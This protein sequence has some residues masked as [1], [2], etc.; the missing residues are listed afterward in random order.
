MKIP[1]IG[2]VLADKY[3]V[4]AIVGH[5][6]MGV[7]L[8][9]RHLELDERVAIKLIWADEKSQGPD[10]IARFVREA[11]LA[12]KI[13][14]EHVVRVLDVARLPSGEPYIVMELLEG[15]DLGEVIAQQGPLP[16]DHAALYLLQAC[17]ALAEA[18]ALG[19]VHR[20]L[21]PANLYLTT[22]P[23]GQPSIKVLDFGISKLVGTD[24]AGSVTKTNTII[25]SPFYM[26]PDQLMQARDVDA[27]SDVWALGVTLFQL[28]TGRC[29]FVA[30]EIPRVIAQVLQAPT[31]PLRAFRSDAPAELEALVNAALVKDR[32]QRIQDVGAFGRALLPFAPEVGRFSVERIVA[33]LERAQNPPSSVFSST[34]G[35]LSGTSNPAI[36]PSATTGGSSLDLKTARGKS[37]ALPIAAVLAALLIVAVGAVTLLLLLRKDPPAPAAVA[38]APAVVV[39]AS[40]VEPAPPVAAAPP[41]PAP[42][43]APE[44]APSVTPVASAAPTASTRKVVPSRPAAA[45]PRPAK[46]KPPDDDPF[47]GVR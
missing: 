3:A 35:R 2:D 6:G 32:A 27:R 28:L 16:I 33:V 8:A 45:A 36:T 42:N 25:G 31:P 5:G 21:K 44:I 12:R 20:D 47:G 15:L 19:I 46:P 7:V 1:A 17:E 41:G 10:F 13:K 11:K 24:G 34:S 26:S 18:H 40:A 38:S 37:S 30:D 43:A 23:D 9:A 4:E 39:A 14:S 29:P 22:R